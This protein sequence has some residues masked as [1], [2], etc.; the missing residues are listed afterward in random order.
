MIKDVCKILGIMK[1]CVLKKTL[2]ISIFSGMNL[3]ALS[4]PS[5]YIC[6]DDASIKE[7]QKIVLAMSKYKPCDVLIKAVIEGPSIIYMMY[8][9]LWKYRTM[10]IMRKKLYITLKWSRSIE[11]WSIWILSSSYGKPEKQI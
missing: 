11:R 7:R 9:F 6:R 5:T 8:H 1:E 10:Y 3:Y 4:E 2:D